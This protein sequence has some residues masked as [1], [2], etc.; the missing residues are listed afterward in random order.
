MAFHPEKCMKRIKFLLPK[1][2][3]GKGKYFMNIDSH[4]TQFKDRIITI[5]KPIDKFL[6][7][8]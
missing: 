1:N 3:H 7:H 5:L 2:Q 8:Y 4:L 6:Q